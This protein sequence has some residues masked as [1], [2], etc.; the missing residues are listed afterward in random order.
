M[1]HFYVS[2]QGT[3]MLNLLKGITWFRWFRLIYVDLLWITYDLLRI[4]VDLRRTYVDLR[5]GI[6]I[7]AK[8]LRAFIGICLW[9]Y[10]FVAW[11][12]KMLLLRGAQCPGGF[13]SQPKP[14]WV[15][16]ACCCWSNKNK[17]KCLPRY[18]I[19]EFLGNWAN[20]LVRQHILN[21]VKVPQGKYL[22]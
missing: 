11:A 6:R 2:S 10:H 20:L 9:S 16:Q 18:E 22:E 5:I 3:L 14:L 15:P 4:Y 12:A 13:E 17:S 7:V 1:F 8:T 21:E 19:S